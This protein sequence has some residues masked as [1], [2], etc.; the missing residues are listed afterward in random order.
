[1]RKQLTDYPYGNLW[2]FKKIF[3]VFFL[4]FLSYE[5]LDIRFAEYFSHIQF[6]IY[7]IGQFVASFF[8][9]KFIFVLVL[10]VTIISFYLPPLKPYFKYLLTLL[11]LLILGQIF[12]G[13]MKVVVGRSRPELLLS[14]NIYTFQPFS[15]SRAYLS[16]PSGHTINITIIFFY[17]ATLLPKNRYY[18]WS[19]GL[20]FS[21]F[22]VLF[23]QHFLSDWFFTTYLSAC[24][25]TF[26]LF[27]CDHLSQITFIKG[28]FTRLGIK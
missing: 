8:N 16:F 11:I 27:F 21:F 1:M 14:D 10:G 15:F 18:F 26:G 7:P 3:F 2:D 20:F 19:I 24:L 9:G 6:Y 23:I 5:F 25:I 28:L 12:L 22:R 17:M 13:V 4:S